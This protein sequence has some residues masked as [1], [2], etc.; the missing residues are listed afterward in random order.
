MLAMITTL[1]DALRLQPLSCDYGRNS[2]SDYSA[3]GSAI[4]M[5]NQYYFKN[6]FQKIIV[7]TLTNLLLDLIKQLK[8]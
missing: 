7:D 5:L 8:V 6:I 4:A 2:I 1:G 3:S